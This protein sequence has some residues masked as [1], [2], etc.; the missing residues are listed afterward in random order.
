VVLQQPQPG[1]EKGKRE[2]KLQGLYNSLLPFGAAAG[3]DGLP[4]EDR[5]PFCVLNWVERDGRRVVDGGRETCNFEGLQLAFRLAAAGESDREVARALNAA[6]YR[7]TGNR[8]QN[9]FQKGTVAEILTNRFYWGELPVYEQ[10]GNGSGTA[11]P[12]QVGWTPGKHA[13]FEGFDE[14]LWERVQRTREKNRW[15]PAKV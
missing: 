14:E 2:R 11:R 6:G 3:P 15:R 12:V 5:R 1:D 4:V 13:A 10:L 9:P 7:T 8:G